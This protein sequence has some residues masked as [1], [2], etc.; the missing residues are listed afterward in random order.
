MSKLGKNSS[1]CTA[2]LFYAKEDDSA[3][4]SASMNLSLKTQSLLNIDN[5]AEEEPS[6]VTFSQ[7]SSSTCTSHETPSQQDTP[8]AVSTNPLPQNNQDASQQLV[9]NVQTSPKTSGT[10][11]CNE[12]T[13][14]HMSSTDLENTVELVA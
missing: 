14:Q 2:N 12:E 6:D 13:S 11:V 4:L 1:N 9:I 3:E 7:E 8:P 10:D 5:N